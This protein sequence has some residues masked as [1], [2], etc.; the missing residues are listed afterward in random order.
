M[1][2]DGSGNYTLPAGVNPV[3]T[4]T[5]I[6]SNWGNTTLEDVAT[7]M[8]DSL[9]RSGNGG[10]LAP[11]RATDGTVSAPSM[12]FNS[13]TNSGIY[14]AGTNDY[15]L[16]VNGVDKARITDTAGMAAFQVYNSTTSTW[17]TLAMHDDISAGLSS[18]LVLG[19]TT[20]SNS[21]YV[22]AGFGVRFYEGATNFGTI[23]GATG[24][25]KISSNSGSSINCHVGTDKKL[26][27]NA[28]G[29]D[30]TGTT[31]SDKVI[32]SDNGSDNVQLQIT[33]GV[34]ANL[35]VNQTADQGGTVV[36]ENGTGD[37]TFKANDF[38]LQD[39][40]DSTNRFSFN[41]LQTK[42]YNGDGNVEL[43]TRTSNDG[44]TFENDVYI[45]DNNKLYFGAGNDLRIYH[46]DNTGSGGS[47]NNYMLSWLTDLFIG[48]GGSATTN[49]INFHYNGTTRFFID[50]TGF[51]SNGSALLPQSIG[52]LSS[53][54][55]LDLV[56]DAKI[57][58][59][60]GND[61]EI[62][63][64]GSN[65]HIV[66]KGTGSL[67]IDSAHF[68]IRSGDTDSTDPTPTEHIRMQ[69]LAG[70]TGTTAF[71]A[72]NESSGSLS[73]G[74]TNPRLEITPISGAI[75]GQVKV[76][77]KM[78]ID[79]DPV[80]STKTGSGDLGVVGDISATNLDLNGNLEIDGEITKTTSGALTVNNSATFVRT[81]GDNTAL[82]VKN[83]GTPSETFTC[84]ASIEVG[85][86]GGSFIDVKKPNS[87]DYDLRIEHGVNADN[88]SLITSKHPLIV[89]TQ[90]GG[91]EVTIKREGSTKLA[92]SSTGISVT[93][94]VTADGFTGSQTLS[95]N[96]T[97]TDITDTEFAGFVGTK[98]IYTGSGTGD[99]TLPD[100][101]A[102]DVGKSW[103][104]LNMG[105]GALTVKRDTNTQ[106][107]KFLNGSS[108]SAGTSNLTLQIGSVTEIICTGAD[109]YVAFG[110]GIS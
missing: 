88:E 18:V 47:A 16:A 86:N 77:G 81:S 10:M 38:Y 7:A 33:N 90:T 29:I 67:S 46:V 5:T 106:T 74:M 43:E 13:E 9:S 99:I 50:N 8:T 100:A 71:S 83:T 40:S 87:D 49:R 97:D 72:G 108:I 103:V 60:T 59:G 82:T 24:E 80:D 61:L 17:E 92:T 4:G 109:N 94:T 20:G 26:E 12:S 69:V 64:D 41:E 45:K 84:Y 19:N 105:S 96:I 37:L 93:G 1:S 35:E 95:N 31:T 54:D 55:T 34:G 14:R 32:I 15:R 39:S 57:R 53:T 48:I 52:L 104:I 51:K 73:T 65:S 2:R 70:A 44:V 85:G 3:T 91:G 11:F 66:D 98:I 110:A 63:H 78:I 79:Q 101:V 21:I 22:N 23:L 30:V 6:T 68:A 89:Q 75:A 58:L 107:I 62:Y 27:I 36:Q 102:G 42:I 76:R 28:T 25:L 56:D